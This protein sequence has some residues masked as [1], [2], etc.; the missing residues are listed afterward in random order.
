MKINMTRTGPEISNKEVTDLEER[1]QYKLPQEYK[2]FLLRYNGGE[3]APYFFSVPD[4]EYKQSLVSELKGINP[5]S[6]GLDLVR[7]FEIKQYD[8]PKGVISIGSDPGGNLILINLINGK[9]YFW[10]HENVPND[11]DKRIDEFHNVYFLSN[12]FNQFINSLKYENE[13][14]Q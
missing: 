10:D 4:W 3:P 7:I 1:I 5:N 2:N 6:V 9:I 13:L 11:T 12:S 14:Q 8:L